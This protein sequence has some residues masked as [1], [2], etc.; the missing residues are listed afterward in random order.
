MIE[1]QLDDGW[2]QSSPIPL[3]PIE[4]RPEQLLPTQ[5]DFA[6]RIFEKFL[7]QLRALLPGYLYT[8]VEIRCGSP[9]QQALSEALSEDPGGGCTVLLD[10]SPFPGKARLMF[11][12]HFSRS[13][14][15]ILLGAPPDAP[16]APAEE[17]SAICVPLTGMDLQILQGLLDLAVA[18]LGE[19]W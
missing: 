3:S 4:C 10:L 1:S 13:V 15:E 9:A 11:G 2:M 6:R 7:G 19:A 18:E 8:P 17:T 12:S 16:V 5:V 14:L